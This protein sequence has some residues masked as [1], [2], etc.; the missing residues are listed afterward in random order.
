M[1]FEEAIDQNFIMILDPS[2]QELDF[3][4]VL[5]PTS[6][7][8]S[9]W[10]DGMEIAVT[11]KNEFGKVHYRS[12]SAPKDTKNP[13]YFSDFVQIASE[14]EVPV[15]AVVHTFGDAYLGQDPNYTITRAGSVEVRE[16]VCPT[17]TSA[18]KY[19]ASVAKEVSRHNISSLILSEHYFPR[20][21]YCQCRRCRVELRQLLGS[22]VDMTLE[23]I[24]QDEDMYFTYLDWRASAINNSLAEMVDTVRSEKP[25]L[26]IYMVV[27]I[28]PVIEWLTGAAMHLGLDTELV[29][30]TLDGLIFNLY[31]WSP[32]LPTQGSDDW[33]RLVER[34]RRIRQQHPRLEIGLMLGNLAAEWDVDWFLALAREIQTTKL[35]GYLN[36]GKLS[37]VKRELHRG[38]S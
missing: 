28:D 12:F 31:P 1:D 3:D 32:L 6:F 15:H 11:A 24:I 5:D 22:A 18:W 13:E 17:N 25:N 33:L 23:E 20:V 9:Y 27:P 37:N 8:T 10:R 14:F 16:F 30:N 19:M 7:F 34:F 21:S 2:S 26:P 35:F 4:Q 36:P 29:G 38:M